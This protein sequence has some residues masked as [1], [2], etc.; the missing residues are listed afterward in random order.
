MADTKTEKHLDRVVAEARSAFG[1]ELVSVVL[2]GSGARAGLFDDR[3]D[4]NLAIV[5][6]EVSFA[7]LRR[8]AS[9]LPGWRKLG[10]ASPLFVDRGFL[11]RARDVFPMEILDIRAEH[12]VLHGEDAFAGLEIDFDHLRF[13]LEQEARGK[14]L[15]LRTLF[16]EVGGKPQPVRDLMV[17]SSKTFVILIRAL[18]RFRRIDVPAIEPRVL[19]LFEEEFVLPLPALR[20]VLLV[21]AGSAGWERDT[22]DT[23]ADYLADVEKLVDRIDRAVRGEL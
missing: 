20:E 9:C 23:F 18:L 10:C 11:E 8:L 4:L 13:Q 1:E 17:D 6:E 5:V 2:Y 7:L 3:S 16:A 19:D 22:L 21:R 14:L 15:R 12:R